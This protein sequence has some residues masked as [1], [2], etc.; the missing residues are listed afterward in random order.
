MIERLRL[1]DGKGDNT[2][3]GTSQGGNPET[4]VTRT[5]TVLTGGLRRSLSSGK[6]LPS[7]GKDE[8]RSLNDKQSDRVW[9]NEEGASRT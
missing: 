7:L 6:E 1:V 2:L 4:R 8:G 3:Y 9:R 5:G